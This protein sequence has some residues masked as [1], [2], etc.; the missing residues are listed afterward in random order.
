MTY[1]IYQVK[2]TSECDKYRFANVR[3]LSANSLEISRGNYDRIYTG[4][5]EDHGQGHELML[6]Y[7]FT[8][9]N[10]KRPDDFRGHS[11]SVSDVVELDG[12]AFYC[13][14]FSWVPIEF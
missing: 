2:N 4:D 14:S 13:N 12:Q 9:F 7:L 6:E 3:D 5:I 8:C 11:M 1:T 10:M